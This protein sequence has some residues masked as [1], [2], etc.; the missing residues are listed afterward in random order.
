MHGKGINKESDGIGMKGLWE[1]NKI[2]NKEGKK[3][4]D[5]LP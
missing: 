4:K 5:S 1:K 2:Q 3:E